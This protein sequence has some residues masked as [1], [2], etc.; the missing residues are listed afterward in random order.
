MTSLPIRA[1][2][3]LAFLLSGLLGPSEAATIGYWRFEGADNT[4]GFLADSSG[5]G[6]TLTESN[7]VTP[8]V[9]T[10]DNP[11]PQTGASNLQAASFNAAQ[12]DRFS[13]SDNSAFAV[14]DFTIEAYVNLS[15]ATNGQTRTIA[16]QEGGSSSNFSWAFSVTAP[17]SGL[18]V[19]N[20]VL[21]ISSNGTTLQPLDSNFQ[22]ALNTNYYVAV[23]VDISDT[24]TNGVTFYIKNLST[25]SSLQSVGVAH[26][27][28]SLFNSTAAF[29]ISGN[30]RSGATNF[31]DGT[32]DEVRFSNTA[33]SSSELLVVPEPAV[34][35][36]LAIAGMVLALRRNRRAAR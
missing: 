1:I 9:S 23:S 22:L 29:A 7:T 28:T 27:G 30:G 35:P 19:R 2:P 11:I 8:V 14:S 32:I 12:S 17:D 4:S 6:L 18:G 24:S 25:P 5:N 10:F 21:Q 3:A 13:V 20:L 16:S 33:L 15:S 36:L 26:T 31:W 34:L